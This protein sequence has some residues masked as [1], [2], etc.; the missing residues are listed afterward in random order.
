MSADTIDLLRQ[1]ST[2]IQASVK[3]LPDSDGEPASEGDHQAHDLACALSVEANRLQRRAELGPD[4]PAG[5]LSVPIVVRGVDLVAH[6]SFDLEGNVEVAGAYLG[7]EDVSG[8]M[9]EDELALVVTAAAER[10]A[11]AVNDDM[12]VEADEARRRA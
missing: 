7:C 3:T 12:D 2:Y 1:A 4:L 5:L 10:E 6:Y 11:R 9:D 8:L